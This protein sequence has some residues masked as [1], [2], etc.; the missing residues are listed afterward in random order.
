MDTAISHRIFLLEGIQHTGMGPKGP[1]GRGHGVQDTMA[2]QEQDGFPNPLAE[3][4]VFLFLKKTSFP[5][6]T[7]PFPLSLC[8]GLLL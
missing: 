2:F 4:W 1:V 6:F 8:R 7:F 5:L 3:L